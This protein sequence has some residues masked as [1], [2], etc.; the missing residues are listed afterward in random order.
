MVEARGLDFAGFALLDEFVEIEEERIGVVRAGGGFRVILHR[1]DREIFV[2]Q[3]FDRVVVE[4]DLGDKGA[5]F[6]ERLWIGGETVILR[7]NGDFSGLQVLHGLVA[8]AMAELEFE[9]LSTERVREHLMTE[10]NTE[11]RE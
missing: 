4:V 7:G 3:A 5:T 11:N 9:G 2:A 10:A 8:A 1:E 6:C